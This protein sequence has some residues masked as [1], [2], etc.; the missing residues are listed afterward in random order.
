MPVNSGQPPISDEDIKAAELTKLK[1]EIA[2][3]K[4][5]WLKGLPVLALAATIVG[6]ILQQHSDSLKREAERYQQDLQLL[7]SSDSSERAAGLL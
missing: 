2:G 5:W 1:L 6:L 7:A 3:L 4:R